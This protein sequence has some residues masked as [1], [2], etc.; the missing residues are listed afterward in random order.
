MTTGSYFETK[1]RAV[2]PLCVSAT[3]LSTGKTGGT[4]TGCSLWTIPISS[5]A[6]PN[7]KCRYPHG[8]VASAEL[9]H[10]GM[11]A[12]ASFDAGAP[13]LGPVDM[14]ANMARSGL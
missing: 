2:S 3:A 11:F 9:S 12:K 6:C 5:P 1:A 7:G 14:V 4:T 10:A 13:L 8:A